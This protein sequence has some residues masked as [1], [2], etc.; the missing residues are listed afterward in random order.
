MAKVSDP[1]A[2]A[3]PFARGVLEGVGGGGLIA[4]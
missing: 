1:L 3:K 2:R 4:L